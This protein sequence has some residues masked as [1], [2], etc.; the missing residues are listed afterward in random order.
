MVTQAQAD[1]CCALSERSPST[2]SSSSHLFSPVTLALLS[3]PASVVLPDLAPLRAVWR[4]FVP[5]AVSTVPRH[6]L[7][8]VFLV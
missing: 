4:A 6:L 2:P 1:T 8:S 3:T 7:L 5:I